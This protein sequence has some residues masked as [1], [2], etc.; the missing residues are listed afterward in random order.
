VAV[1]FNVAQ[2]VT[3]TS[4]AQYEANKKSNDEVMTQTIAPM[5]GYDVQGNDVSSITLVTANV[6]A[7]VGNKTTLT[8]V[9][10]VSKDSYIFNDADEAI[11]ACITALNDSV[12]TGAFDR[13][14]RING[15]AS[16]N[17]VMQQVTTVYITFSTASPTSSP[18]SLPTSQPTRRDL[19]EAN[20]LSVPLDARVAKAKIQYYLGT[21]VGYF[22]G[23]FILL[24]LFSFTRLRKNTARQ[25]YA[26]SYQSYSK[27]CEG[28]TDIALLKELRKK[29][30]LVSEMMKLERTVKLLRGT[31]ID[32]SASS[33]HSLHDISWSE[34]LS[35][36][37][38][39]IEDE[40][41][42]SRSYREYMQQERTLLGC[43][44]LLYP[45]GYTVRVPF[46]DPI[47]LPPGRLEDF[48]LYLC[49]NHPLF[50]CFYFMDGSKL[51]A[52]GHRI[53]YIG[54]DI[55]VFVLYQFSNMLLQYFMLDGHGLGL[56]I[57]ILLITPSAVFVRLVLKYLYVCPFTETVEFQRKYAHYQW[58]I[59][60]LGRLSIVPIMFI[61]SSAL[62]IACLFSSGRSILLIVIKFFM[63]VQFY[64]TIRA[65]INV[66]LLFV[67]G[68]YLRAS[69]LGA[70][71]LLRV[72][73]LYKERIM[74]EQLV[75]DVDYAYRTYP[76]LCGVVV[77]EK[78]LNRE[79]AIK[80]KW[81]ELNNEVVDIEMTSAPTIENP[82]RQQQVAEEERVSYSIFDIES[83]KVL[84][85]ES[86]SALDMPIVGVVN[87]TFLTKKTTE[88]SKY[89]GATAITENP[90]HSKI[91]QSHI[92][93][94]AQE[95]EDE[96]ETSLYQ[97]Y[98][99]ECAVGASND[100]QY[101]TNNEEEISFEEWKINRK[102]SKKAF[103]QGTRGSFIKA[104]Q[105]FE[106]MFQSH[107][108]TAMNSAKNTVHLH[109]GI[110]KNALSR[111][112]STRSHK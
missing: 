109:K 77:I 74:T 102:E 9:Y 51:G 90:L 18:T 87:N 96:D 60:L 34:K 44:P 32:E 78:V 76:V 94:L 3:G 50:S 38:F 35:A 42:Y 52:H 17:N 65:I 100:E 61:M 36:N 39:A 25:L 10:S 48:I 81:I 28:N 79:D 59:I 13:R 80:A 49:H 105:L 64:G 46:V 16:G 88:E 12:S 21:F 73:A 22:L 83:N 91:N 86:T 97:E 43:A 31:S 33:Q 110:A 106:E 85:E 29:N 107:S 92:A 69:L 53:L 54:K 111:G 66:M 67:D 37:V 45:N 14:L 93:P 58:A 63:I 4:L 62:I 15:A 104:Y 71:D 70:I 112:I 2:V 26:S 27:Y 11:S 20:I 1:Y 7:L 40:D 99:Q 19:V 98:Q 55:V 95:Q 89:S 6:N 56:M 108:D 23:I 8:L 101:S 5:V 24:Y 72:G 84:A 57:N 103:K 75:L 41:K 30:L 82:L 68:Y 47:E